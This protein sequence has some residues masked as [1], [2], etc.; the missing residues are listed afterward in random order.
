MYMK[1]SSHNKT[2]WS[3]WKPTSAKEVMFLSA[4]VSFVCKVIQKMLY[5]D[6]HKAWWKD[7][8]CNWEE[9]SNI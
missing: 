6:F 3:N 7:E 2:T 1:W 4:F 5:I 9:A 8:L